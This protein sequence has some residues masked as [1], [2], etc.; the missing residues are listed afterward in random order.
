MTVAVNLLRQT[1]LSVDL[2]HALLVSSGNTTAAK[3]NV[4]FLERQLFRL[5]D[6]E[7][8]KGRSEGDEA[9]KEDEGTW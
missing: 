9:A 5:R 7:P 3:D 6:V 1:N 4:H 8:D 2:V